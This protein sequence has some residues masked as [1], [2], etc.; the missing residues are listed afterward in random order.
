M[1]FLTRTVAA[2]GLALTL[3]L[4]ALA[5]NT[6]APNTLV[7]LSTAEGPIDIVLLDSQAPVT[8]TNFLSYVRRGDY[9]RSFF[10]RLVPRFVLQGGGFTAPPVARVPTQAAIANEF[11]ASRS[12][13]RG[14]VAMAKLG[15]NPNSATSQWFVNLA[16]NAA[17]LD[18]QNGGFT[19]FGRITTPS[20]AIVDR[21][22]TSPRVDASGCGP[23][24]SAFDSLPVLR[25]T[26]EN[27]SIVEPTNL[28][29]IT[30]AAE[31]TSRATALPAERIFDFVEAAFP[32]YANPASPATLTADG[33]TYRF[34]S[35][36]N[37]YL[38]V[39]DGKVYYLV[40]SLSPDIQL[41][42]TVE[43]WLAFAQGAGY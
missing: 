5:Q 16:N 25:D 38:G 28:R 29:M 40:P 24:F 41:L 9:N 31:L 33:Y 32:Q 13:V 39:K 10:H 19:V 4:T 12:N 1:K 14:T 7:R 15:N 2:V 6:T 26:P 23:V 17:N 3:P 42:G 37:A 11:S 34:Y 18:A 8:V 27:C 22:A 43:E 36:T 20:M 21:L 35:A 30:V